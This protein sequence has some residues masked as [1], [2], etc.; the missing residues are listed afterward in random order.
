MKRKIFNIDFLQKDENLYI[1]DIHFLYSKIMELDYENRN[2][3]ENMDIFN[4]EEAPLFNQTYK[5]LT[6]GLFYAKAKVDKFDLDTL[7][8]RACGFNKITRKINNYRS[9]KVIITSNHNYMEELKGY[10]DEGWN[11]E[12]IPPIIIDKE[13]CVMID[14]MNWY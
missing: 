11:I 6:V 4:T 10:Y 1:E 8:I 7:L 13:K 12:Y 9:Y 5:D 2:K 14:S 3:S